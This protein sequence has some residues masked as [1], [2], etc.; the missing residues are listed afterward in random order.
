VSPGS[1]TITLTSSPTTVVGADWW[2]LVYDNYGD[3]STVT[4]NAKAYAWVGDTATRVI[5]TSTD[6]SKGWAP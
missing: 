6:A 1:S 4:A 2:D 5:G 3:G